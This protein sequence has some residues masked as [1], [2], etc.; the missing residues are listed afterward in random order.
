MPTRAQSFKTIQKKN[1]IQKQFSVQENDKIFPVI[2]NSLNLS[3]PEENRSSKNETEEKIF[4]TIPNTK[5]N[6]TNTAYPKIQFNENSNSKP[7]LQDD[8]YEPMLAIPKPLFDGRDN[9]IETDIL[10]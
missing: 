2:L 1:S 10:I 9:E 4:S 3:K 6:K 7:K 8:Y 5:V